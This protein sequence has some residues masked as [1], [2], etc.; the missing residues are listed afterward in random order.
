MDIHPSTSPPLSKHPPSTAKHS[1]KYAE[2]AGGM[3]PSGMQYCYIF[4]Y[5]LKL[6]LPKEV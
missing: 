1:G 6:T 2:R 3:H 4:F 5:L